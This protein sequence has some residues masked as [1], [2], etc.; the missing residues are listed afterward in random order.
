MLSSKYITNISRIV[1]KVTSLQRTVYL[2][3]GTIHGICNFN[4]PNLC[5]SSV[6]AIQFVR[7]YAKGKDKKKD[8]GETDSMSCLF[9]LL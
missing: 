4:E 1:T 7:Q 8:K 5:H 6:P 3:A 9:K 2:T